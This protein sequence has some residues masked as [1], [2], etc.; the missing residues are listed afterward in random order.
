M[1]SVFSN[2]NSHQNNV[3][4]SSAGPAFVYIPVIG[5]RG[6]GAV[7]DQPASLGGED[8]RPPLGVFVSTK[9]PREQPSAWTQE[10]GCRLEESRESQYIPI[11]VLGTR[12]SKPEAFMDRRVTQT[13][14]LEGGFTKEFRVTTKP[15]RQSFKTTDHFL[16]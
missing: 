12:V 5:R 14:N 1:R 3:V 11:P 9:A 15:W 4:S 13:Q 7:C 6:C 10:G 2:M 16:F 8:R